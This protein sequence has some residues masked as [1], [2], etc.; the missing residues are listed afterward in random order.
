MRWGGRVVI[1]RITVLLVR[2]ACEGQTL[3]IAEA[4]PQ[5]SPFGSV[6]SWTVRPIQCAYMNQVSV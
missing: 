3:G 2:F 6:R 1:G 5:S 4:A